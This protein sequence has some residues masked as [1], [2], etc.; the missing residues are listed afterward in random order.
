MSNCH[1]ICCIRY[2]RDAI[3]RSTAGFCFAEA[4]PHC[5]EVVVVVV[6]VVLV[7]AAPVWW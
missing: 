4:F 6:V 5:A 7:V 2:K 1:E 3:A